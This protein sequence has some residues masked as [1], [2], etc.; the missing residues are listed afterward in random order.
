MY[1]SSFMWWEKFNIS[2]TVKLHHSKNNRCLRCKS[3]QTVTFV[4]VSFKRSVMLEN[5]LTLD[6]EHVDL[7]LESITA[8][9]IWKEVSSLQLWDCISFVELVLKL[10][11]NHE[12][13]PKGTEPNICIS[14]VIKLRVWSTFLCFEIKQKSV[15]LLLFL[16]KPSL[17]LILHCNS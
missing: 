15:I 6:G 2:P 13:V 11:I 12:K 4:R 8:Q 10:K 1:Q 3:V 14:F 5:K 9:C 16:K 7:I 17:T